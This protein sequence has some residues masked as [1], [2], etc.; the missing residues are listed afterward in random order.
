MRDVKT[1]I[2]MQKLYVDA[3]RK[4]LAAR[5]RKADALQA[6]IAELRARV[7]SEKKNHAAQKEGG[8][9]FGAFLR[10]EIDRHEDLQKALVLANREI[11]V[12][13]EKLA[14]LFE[15]LKR[16]EIIQ[17]NWDEEARAEEAR[18]ETIDYD[19]QAGMR[20]HDRKDKS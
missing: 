17:E 10:K 9:I 20:H 7:E 15:E 13:R 12:E 2:K 5:Q 11:D 3:Q 16:Y 8:F 1:L 18:V 14:V 4:V 19:E 6:A